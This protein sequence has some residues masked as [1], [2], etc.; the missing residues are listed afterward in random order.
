MYKDKEKRILDSVRK[1]ARKLRDRELEKIQ[2]DYPELRKTARG[3]ALGQ[4]VMV[5]ILDRHEQRYTVMAQRYCP[6]YQVGAITSKRTICD[7]CGLKDNPAC[8]Y[9]GLDLP[10]KDIVI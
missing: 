10:F 6:G 2:R 8:D 9:H 3:Y 4:T 1:S 7:N 5:E